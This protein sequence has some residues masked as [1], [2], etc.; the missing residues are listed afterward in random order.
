MPLSSIFRPSA[1]RRRLPRASVKRNRLAGPCNGL[2]SLEPRTLFSAFVVNSLL[3]APDAIPGDGFAAAADGSTTLR[4]A[5]DE[6]NAM[7][8]ADAIGFDPSLYASGPATITLGT[9]LRI[10]DALTITG[11]GASLLTVSGG[12]VVRVF[13]ID[14]RYDTP[15]FSATIEDLRIADGNAIYEESGAGIQSTKDLTL[16]QVVLEGNRQ[17]AVIN[18]ASMAIYDSLIVGNTGQIAAGI[19]DYGTMLLVNSTVANNSGGQGGYVH[20]NSGT[21]Y[22]YNSTITGN[23][24][25]GVTINN[26][27][28]QIASTIVSG[29]TVDIRRNAGSLS[30]SRNVIGTVQGG[31]NGTNEENFFGIDPMLGPLADNGGP[32]LTRA[33]LAGSPAIDAGSNS[34]GL[35]TDQRGAGFARVTGAG[36]DIGAYE[37]AFTT[38]DPSNLVV[39]TL[40]DESDGDYSAGDLSLREAIE[41]ANANVGAAVIR[42]VDGMTGTITLGGTEL[43]ITDAVTITGPGA[44]LLTV[45]GGGASRVFEVNDGLAGVLSAEISGLRI[46]GGSAHYFESGAGVRNFERLTLRRVAVEGNRASGIINHQDLHVD[47]SLISDNHG[48]V[49]G[50]IINYGALTLVNSTVSGNTAEDHSGGIANGGT[51]YIYNSTITRNI[52]D[53][54]NN[55]LGAEG[56]GIRAGGA[57]TLV[58]TIVADNQ[59][60]TG[61]QA[62]ASDLFIAS[63]ATA[64]HSLI[65]SSA[66]GSISGMDNIYG[67]DP[68]LAPLG[69][70]DGSTRTHALLAGSPAIDRGANP[71]ELTTDQRGASRIQG[72]GA[73]MGA[74]ESE[75]TTLDPSKLVVDTLVDESDGDYSVGDLSLREAIELA[76]ANPGAATIRF[77]AG[78]T[79]TIV[80]GGTELRITDGLTI[81]GPGANLLTVSGNNASRV[82]NVDDGLGPWI[83]VVLEDLTSLMA[84]V[85]TEAAFIARRR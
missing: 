39:D 85:L 63:T 62:F 50:G 68:G 31:I 8:G 55:G 7:V 45:S 4:A 82:F 1:T 15:M 25:A 40:A 11:P 66:G 58:S 53:S 79:G 19:I 29:N 84:G 5:I 78:L 76:N 44:N 24:G 28:V 65:E 23:S 70:N 73:D 71:R 74:Y 34:L 83:D 14:G 2:E 18:Q 81:T 46:A 48:Y 16:R 54:D 56:G 35:T 61:A 67:S 21:S 43:R 52:A 47:E 36:A 20:S 33:I 80:L 51:A 38:I 10:T 12:G 49:G 30:A 42:L 3:D 75:F 13:N 77:F 69:T 26:G 32:T 27:Q 22:I 6:S 64:F 59:G 9:E 37:S 57:I 72:R 41:L 17:S 60:R